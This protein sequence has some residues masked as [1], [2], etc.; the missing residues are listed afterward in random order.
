M[1]RSMTVSYR[2]E[3]VDAQM[4]NTLDPKSNK[5]PKQHPIIGR[6]SKIDGFLKLPTDRE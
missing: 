6:E 5:T 2:Q 4:E 3:Q 1:P